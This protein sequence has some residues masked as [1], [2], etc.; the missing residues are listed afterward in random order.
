[1]N[2]AAASPSH[3]L[4]RGVFEASPE[5]ELKKAGRNS[6]QIRLELGKT[7]WD[8]QGLVIQF[9]NQFVAAAVIYRRV[10]ER[11]AENFWIG[12]MPHPQDHPASAR[13]LP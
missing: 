3:G 12:A 6:Q 11:I 5:Q 8:C 9:R 4:E 10:R 2:E 13:A 1:M 7:R